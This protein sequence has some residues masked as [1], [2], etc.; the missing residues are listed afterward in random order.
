MKLEKKGGILLKSGYQFLF[1]LKSD[2]HT[3][4]FSEAPHALLRRS[5]AQL[6]NVCLGTKL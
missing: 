3:S 6:C 2:K 5:A 4:I 1:W